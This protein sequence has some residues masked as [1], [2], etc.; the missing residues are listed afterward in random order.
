M[1]GTARCYTSY[2]KPLALIIIFAAS[3]VI[4]AILRA[5]RHAD[6]FAV[7]PSLGSQVAAT[8]LLSFVWQVPFCLMLQQ[9]MGIF[10]MLLLNMGTYSRRPPRLPWSYFFLIRRP[11][12]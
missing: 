8:A 1:S 6:V 5:K 2:G 10:P 7:Y 12:G 3:V 11:P 9:I 4:A